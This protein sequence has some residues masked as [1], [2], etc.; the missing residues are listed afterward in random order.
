MTAALESSGHRAGQYLIFGTVGV[1]GMGAVHL[2]RRV[3]PAGFSRIVAVKRMHPHLMA[4]REFVNSFLDEARIAARISHPNVVSIHDVVITAGEVLLV[5]EYVHGRS[6]SSLLRASTQ[7][8]PPRIAVTIALDMLHGLQAAHDATDER[9]RPL[10]IVHRDVSPH[11]VIVGADGIARVLDFGV[12]KALGRLQ[13]TSDGAL[14]GK[15]AYMAPE[16]LAEKVD[17]TSV[18][19]FGAGIVMWEMFAGRRYFDES[20]TNA[21]LVK[22]VL[23]C[24]YRHLDDPSL[25]KVDRVLERALHPLAAERFASCQTLAT[26]LESAVDPA[27]RV[28]VKAWVKHIAKDALEHTASVIAQIEQSVDSDTSLGPVVEG[29]ATGTLSSGSTGF[30]ETEPSVTSGTMPIEEDARRAG[31]SGVTGIMMTG[32]GTGTT[33]RRRGRATLLL[34]A[35]ACISV[36]VGGVAL[37]RRHGVAAGRSPASPPAPEPPTAP[38]ARGSP[39]GSASLA[40]SAP[41]VSA[42]TTSSVALAVPPPAPSP[43]RGRSTPG[44]ARPPS[45]RASASATAPPVAREPEPEAPT[46]RK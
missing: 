16:R 18:D 17:T 8:V 40:L 13:T 4:E 30:A 38:P 10:G 19:V 34:A 37:G 41:P 21:I 42:A 29:T 44:G 45:P 23:E 6:L 43:R 22:T 25:A 9:G 46:D 15:L 20:A 14:K 7:P 11:N 28:D 33:P 39:A 27:S 26:A 12:A 31:R 36:A 32:T 35:A 2:G 1:G 3:G 5:M 24:R